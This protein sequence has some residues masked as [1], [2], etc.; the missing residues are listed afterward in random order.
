MSAA[1]PFVQQ[2]RGAGGVGPLGRA[3]ELPASPDDRAR[4][5]QLLAYDQLHDGIGP[6]ASL[7]PAR[8]GIV[9]VEC[10][11]KARRR[12]Y[13]RQKLALLLTS[14][15]HFAVEQAR[16]GVAVRYLVDDSYAAAAER[17]ARRLGPLLLMRP[18]EYELRLELAPLIARGLL[19]EVRHDGWLTTAEEF[20]AWAGARPPWRLDAFYRGARRARDIL[21]DHRGAPLGGTYSH[22]A[23]NRKRW[24]GTPAAP[25]PPRFSV[26][27]IT[28]EV[29]ALIQ[30]EFADH[31]GQ[32]DLA[33][34]P[35]SAAD[36]QTLWRWARRNC[37]PTFGPYEDAMST[38][39][40]GLF[41]TRI[42]PLLN[43]HRVLPR[44]V[45]ASALHEDDDDDDAPPIP[46]ASREGF[47]RQ[48]L[49]WREFVHHVHERPRASARC[50]GWRR[51]SR[52]PP[53]TAGSRAG[54]AP[55]GRGPEPGAD[56]ARRRHTTR[57]PAVAAGYWGTPSGLR[58]LD[59]VVRD[60]WR[61]GY[62]HHITRL[63]VL[64]NLGTLLGVSPRALS[65]LVLGRLRRRLRLGR[66]AERA[67]MA[68]FALGGADDDQALR[69]RR[70]Y[71]HKMSDYCRGCAFDPKTTCPLTRLYWAYLGRQER[72]L[73]GNPRMMVPLGA[74]RKRAPHQRDEDARTFRAVSATLGA[75]G[76]VTP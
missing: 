24:P 30:R 8:R 54:V 32:L 59:H 2:L 57:R 52:P 60:V 37:L 34:I 6:L 9:L 47:V 20:Q 65:R 73:T 38:A 17:A 64:G 58:C 18:A 33:A 45:L 11:A 74:L 40:S 15:R 39:S 16:A 31:P 10:P 66:R 44:D 36:A 42:S 35:A 7:P 62:S 50:R 19:R 41:H 1:S 22:D 21:M 26:D 68:T 5:W 29:G 53:A 69:R 46:L 14:L 3:H 67:G 12:P 76:R 23:D 56:P 71:L 63:M 48:V 49:G 43:L 61:D 25:E 75:G 72:A 55:S 27:D 4:T 13:H 28:A 70:A 51:R